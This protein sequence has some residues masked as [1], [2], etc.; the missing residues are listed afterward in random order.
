MKQYKKSDNV[1]EAG[2]HLKNGASPKSRM[3]RGN[4]V[5]VKLV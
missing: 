4:N 1:M 3:S 5:K 2:D